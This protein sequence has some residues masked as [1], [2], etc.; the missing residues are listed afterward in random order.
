ML[1]FKM[2]GDVQ[3]KSLISEQSSTVRLLPR[4][5]FPSEARKQTNKGACHIDLSPLPLLYLH[6]LHFEVRDSGSLILRGVFR[7]VNSSNYH[8]P[9]PARYTT[10]GDDAV[11]QV[12]YSNRCCKARPE[13]MLIRLT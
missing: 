11:L 9:G 5:Q 6:Y 3:V 2:G 4:I 7:L 8:V 1:S 10:G 13:E 12:C